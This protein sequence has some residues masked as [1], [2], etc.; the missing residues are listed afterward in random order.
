MLERQW[1]RGIFVFGHIL[2]AFYCQL[3]FSV[4]TALQ[5]LT[6][7]IR[8]ASQIATTA[9]TTYRD[10]VKQTLKTEVNTAILNTV[11]EDD[12]ER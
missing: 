3:F 6:N 4:S 11:P 8:Y 12:T 1:G 7:L 10:E 5:A 9:S 2:L